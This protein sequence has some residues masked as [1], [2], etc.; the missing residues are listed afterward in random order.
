MQVVH[1]NHWLLLVWYT[2]V[3]HS[4]KNMKSNYHE[5]SQNNYLFLLAWANESSKPIIIKCDDLKGHGFVLV[6][7][8]PSSLK[9]AQWKF[10]YVA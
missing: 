10:H 9:M 3:R 8:C 2:C 4:K 1:V 6:F 7:S 5:I